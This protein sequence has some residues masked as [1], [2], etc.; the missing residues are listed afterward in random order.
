MKLVCLKDFFFSFFNRCNIVPL[1]HYYFT[2]FYNFSNKVKLIIGTW[3]CQNRFYHPGGST[4]M[5]FTQ[6][7]SALKVIFFKNILLKKNFFK[8]PEQSCYNVWRSNNSFLLTNKVPLKCYPN[9]SKTFSSGMIYKR[10]LNVLR[11]MQE[12]F[13]NVKIQQ[14]RTFVGCQNVPSTV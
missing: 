11:T 8:S 5:Q 10:C 4:E 13:L 12:R 6:L 2:K 7:S 1:K 9:V 14:I 3:G